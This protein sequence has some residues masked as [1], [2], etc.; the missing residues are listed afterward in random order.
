LLRGILWAVTIPACIFCRTQLLLR[1]ESFQTVSQIEWHFI[2]LIRIELSL[3]RLIFDIKTEVHIRVLCSRDI[4][5][6]V[7]GDSTR[8]LAV[9]GL[10]HDALAIVGVGIS[11]AAICEVKR[12]EN[13]LHVFVRVLLLVACKC[14]L[15]SASIHDTVNRPIAAYLSS[16]PTT[17]EHADRSKALVLV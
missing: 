1:R 9:E 6:A 10:V 4:A 2:A 5:T 14:L 12:V 13:E 17:H 16:Q 15:V 3:L 7:A 11:R 8:E